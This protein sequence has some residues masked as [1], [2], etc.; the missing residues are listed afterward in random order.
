[1]ERYPVK[2]KTRYTPKEEAKL[3]RIHSEIHAQ[4]KK[5]KRLPMIAADKS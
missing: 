5:E 4:K 2:H 3:M 1:M